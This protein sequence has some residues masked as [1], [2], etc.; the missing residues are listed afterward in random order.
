MFLQSQDCDYSLRRVLI[1]Q[2]D[3]HDFLKKSLE[4]YR[5]SDTLLKE[6]YKYEPTSLQESM[7][8]LTFGGSFENL[9]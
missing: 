4:P 3:S 1:P 7:K 5:C 9:S 8:D 6:Y 2:D